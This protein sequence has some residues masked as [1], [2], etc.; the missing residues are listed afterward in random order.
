MTINGSRFQS[1]N[2]LILIKAFYS[3]NDFG[4]NIS[5]PQW[6]DFNEA[7]P[8]NRKESFFISIPQWSDFNDSAA[9][10]MCPFALFQS[11]N[12]LILI[13]RRKE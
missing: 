3:C 2:G 1:H 4:H 6:S 12:G 11:H 10:I 9:G 13:N 8:F 7:V 5:I